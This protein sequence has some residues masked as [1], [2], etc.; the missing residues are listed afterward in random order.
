M[1]F[2]RSALAVVLTLILM[3]RAG[4]AQSSAAPA[5]S[6]PV[7]KLEQNYPNPFN[8]ETRIPFSVGGYPTCADLSHQYKVTMRILNV[9]VQLVAIPVIQGGAG[10]VAGGQP[11]Q[12]VLLPCGQY[13]AY[14]NGNYLNTSKEAA[15]GVYVYVLEV[16]GHK[17][18]NKMIVMK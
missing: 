3:P 11:L 17:L 14:W 5:Q 13:I 1:R 16:D 8:P 2:R 15:S 18:L 7:A 4:S 10:N 12:N 9:L 6:S